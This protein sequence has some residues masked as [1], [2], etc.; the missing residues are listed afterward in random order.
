MRS[1]PDVTLL[2]S[3]P[4]VT[5]GSRLLAQTVLDAKSETPIDFV[6]MTLTCRVTC[7]VGGG[8]DRSE[9]TDVLFLR[10]W[11]SPGETLTPGEHTF[12]VAFDLPDHLPV[13]YTGKDAQIVYTVRVHVSI[14]WWPDRIETFELPVVWPDSPALPPAVPQSFATSVV[15][16]RGTTPFMEVALEASQLATGE[17][18]AGSVSLQNLRGK[19]IRGVEVAFVEAEAVTQPA[20]ESREGRRYSLRIHDGAPAEGAPLPF[21][22][23]LPEGATP[24]FRAGPVSVT[25]HVEV[26][27]IVAWGDDLVVRA[28]LHVAPR[29]SAPRSA[30]GW[31]AP[32][33]R[34]RR[35]LVWK[36]AAERTGLVSDPEI[37]RMTGLRGRV[38]IEIRT[39]QSD[40]DFWLVAKLGYPSLGLDLSIAHAKWTDFVAPNVVKTGVKLADE[41]FAAHAREH[42]QTL[43]VLT[44]AFMIP[45]LPF[46]EIGVEDRAATL[47]RRGTP[48][49]F[50]AV[51]AFVHEVLDVAT[52]LE[53]ALD[54]VPAPAALAN[55]VPAWRAFADRVRGRLELGRMQVHDAV[56]GID[57]V[58]VGTEWTRN[59]LLVGTRL[60]VVVDPA[61]AAVPVSLEDPSL[62]P[63][64]R[65]AWRDLVA[66][67]H[68]VKIE[69]NAVLVDLDGKLADPAEAL[70]IIELAVALRRALAGIAGG[71]P[72]R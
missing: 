29:A 17:A 33:G 46:E 3:P 35:A 18:L 8:Q 10:E 49:S 24:T 54:H 25:T 12:R 48:H 30:P 20:Y 50:D 32:V 53:S 64:A 23:R 69:A 42:A 4:I 37:E 70:P 59:G 57:R 7:A 22:V 62:S 5:P 65:N 26:R 28:P 15:G 71:G 6:S 1:R 39:E 60:Q 72:F 16:P 19:R 13:T 58:S 27:A 43:A 36:G 41:R 45:L 67:S 56:V 31:V 9:Y 55:D 21:R 52:A 44:P 66:R 68:A 2:L 11:R 51:E 38:A 40:G 34:E 14:P 47:A 61:L 63:A